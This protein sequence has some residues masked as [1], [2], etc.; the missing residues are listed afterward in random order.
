MN[1]RTRAHGRASNAVLSWLHS[2]GRQVPAV[3]LHRPVDLGDELSSTNRDEI[4]D[5]IRLA[6]SVPAGEMIH[7]G[8]ATTHIAADRPEVQHAL[9]H[10]SRLPGDPVDRL[11][12]CL[13]DLLACLHSPKVRHTVAA[14]ASAITRAPGGEMAADDVLETVVLAMAA[15]LPDD[16][17]DGP[18]HPRKIFVHGGPR[19]LR[20]GD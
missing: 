3:S 18:G 7:L 1:Q 14:L 9:R 20:R 6:I 2:R 17:Y 10:A 4:E 12:R 11:E 19:H 16:A 15:E 13:D 8:A 5:H